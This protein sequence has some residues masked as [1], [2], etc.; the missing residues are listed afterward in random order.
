MKRIIFIMTALAMLASCSTQKEMVIPRVVSTIGTATFEDLN[1]QRNDYEIINTVTTE[2]T[3]SFETN[4]SGTKIIISGVDDDFQ[5]EYTKDKKEGWMCKYTGILKYGYIQNNFPE[6]KVN[7]V[8]PEEI[9][10]RLAVYRLVSQM[11]S[12]GGDGLVA[13]SVVTR[14]EQQGNMVYFHATAEAKA[15]KLKAN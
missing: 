2:A 12:A 13:P 9:V 11:K 15:V 1:L 6:T 4:K 8:S 14:I 3:V 10:Y 7:F 5:L